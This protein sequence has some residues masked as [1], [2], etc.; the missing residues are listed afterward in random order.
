MAVRQQHM[1][2]VG[3]KVN[4]EAIMEVCITSYQLLVNNVESNPVYLDEDDYIRRSE[5]GSR[6]ILRL[7]SC[8]IPSIRL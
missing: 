2:T 5:E 6:S 4:L 7:I 1:A 8:T 3:E